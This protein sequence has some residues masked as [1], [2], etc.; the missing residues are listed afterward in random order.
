LA[1]AIDLYVTE[2]SVRLN[3]EGGLH[4]LPVQD[5]NPFKPRGFS[6]KDSDAPQSR[7]RRPPATCGAAVAPK[8]TPIR[9][10]TVQYVERKD[11]HRTLIAGEVIVAAQLGIRRSRTGL[12]PA[13]S[14]GAQRAGM[15]DTASDSDRSII[16]PCDRGSVNNGSL[17]YWTSHAN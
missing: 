2:R 9:A 8:Q 17:S 10:E 6:G 13:R 1:G 11:W 14:A 3:H 7:D 15:R 16:E 12:H 5:R 4:E